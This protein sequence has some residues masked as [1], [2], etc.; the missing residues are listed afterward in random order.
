MTQAR[1]R[2][3]FMRGGTSKAVVF[4]QEDLP[5]DRREW[6][7]IFL[8]VMGS[9]DPNGRQL[10]GMGGGISSLSKI[11]VVGPSTR[12]D[13]D[14]DYTFAQISVRDASVDFSANCGNMSS[15]IGP[16]A[17]EEGLVPTTGDGEAVVRI[18]NTNTS[19]I[20]VSRFRVENGTAVVDGDLSIDGVAGSAAP[21]RLEFTDPGGAKTGRLLPSG[22]ALN[23]LEV[24]GL[25]VINASLVDAANP[26]VFVN[27]ADLGKRG[28]E[29]PDALEADP[30]F[31]D[32]MEAIRRA[33][34]V[35]MGIAKD[36]DEAGR[37][38]SI[39]KVAIVAAPRAMTTLSGRSLTP[40][41]MSILV[42]MISIGQPHRAVPITGALCLAV[43]ARIPASVPNILAHATDEPIRIAHPS[44]VTVVDAK[45]SGT[46][47]TESLHAEYGAVYRTA[48]RLFEGA[49]LYR[50]GR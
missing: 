15:A 24:P 40:S 10:D 41:D 44:G 6:D 27:A 11:C 49:V 34:S 36:I 23:R 19:K 8:G 50:K 3:S 29:L 37:V 17:V 43:A 42:R 46:G 14:V 21:I 12:P 4:R 38:P 7:A 18:H 48:R 30:L 35:H 20:I 16:F 2:A 22:S 9:P 45:V 28:D 47:S 32:R 1:I 31:L 13:A 33:A 25:G 26:C 5:A 39:P